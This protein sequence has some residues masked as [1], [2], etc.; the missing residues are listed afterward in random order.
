MRRLYVQ[1]CPPVATGVRLASPLLGLHHDRAE[2]RAPF[3]DLPAGAVV[4]VIVLVKEPADEPPSLTSLLG[5][6]KG[7]FGSAEEADAYL[8]QERDSWDS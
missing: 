6:T 3:P 8:R 4:E 7:L 2:P 5:S 1:K